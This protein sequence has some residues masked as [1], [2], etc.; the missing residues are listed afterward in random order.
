[1]V[2]REFARRCR[3]AR[4]AFSRV[5][6]GLH[7]FA[8]VPRQGDVEEHFRREAAPHA[9]DFTFCSVD[10][11]ASADWDLS[12][13]WLF[14]LL[15]ALIEEGLIDVVL[16]GPPCSTWSA[17][18]WLPGGPRLLRLCWT[19]PRGRDGLTVNERAYPCLELSRSDGELQPARWCSS[20]RTPS[21]PSGGPALEP[22]PHCLS[23]S[24]SLFL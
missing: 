2:H 21:R 12:Q 5:F 7:L 11:L 23:L 10:L 24:L 22:Q 1:M 8:G 15:S 3:E 19:A 20:P 4:A 17:L 6:V 13:P 16:G 9:F 18:R 14:D